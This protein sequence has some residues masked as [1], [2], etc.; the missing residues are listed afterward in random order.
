M[1]E[2]ISK[3]TILVLLV[4]TIVVSIAS[5]FVTLTMLE[6]PAVTAAPQPQALTSGS[7]QGEVAIAIAK[8]HEPTVSEPVS[9]KIMLSIVRSG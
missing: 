9:G 3:R 1:G 4:L 6:Q 5:T 2:E 7:S 8:P